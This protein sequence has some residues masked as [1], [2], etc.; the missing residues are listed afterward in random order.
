[1]ETQKTKGLSWAGFVAGLTGGVAGTGL[2]LY[3]LN[4]KG[5]LV[6]VGS[7]GDQFIGFYNSILDN[8]GMSIPFFIFAFIM[9]VL[10]FRRL[11]L[12]LTTKSPKIESVADLESKVDLW[13]SIFFGIGVIFTAYGMQKSLVTTLGDL[14]ADTAASRGA[15]YILQSLVHGGILLAL[16][17]TIAGGVGGYIMRVCKTHWLG[18]SLC[19]FYQNEE[20]KVGQEIIDKLDRLIE[21]Q[22][23]QGPDS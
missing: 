23:R 7:P 1:M 13:T 19:A 22:Q 3:F 5:L 6:L 10:S 11:D 9:Y 15:F 16:W 17:T 14:D 2:L 20:S 4:T 18:S 21:L 12:L 8:L